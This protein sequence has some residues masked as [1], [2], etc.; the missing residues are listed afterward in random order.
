MIPVY[1]VKIHEDYNPLNLANDIAIL[2]LRNPA[3]L[4]TT[5]MPICLPHADQNYTGV[6]ATVSGWGRLTEN[7][8]LSKT[9]QEAEVEVVSNDYCAAVYTEDSVTDNH[10]CAGGN[11]TDSCQADSGGPLIPEETDG[12]NYL[13]GITS[14]GRGCGRVG[15]P[16]VYMRVA[17]YLEWIAKQVQ[18]DNCEYLSHLP[19]VNTEVPETAT[20]NF[21]CSCGIRNTGTRIIGGKV[22]QVHE[23]P[24]QVAIVGYYGIQPFCGAVVLSDEWIMTAAHCAVEMHLDD[25]LMLGEHDWKHASE[26]AITL[27]RS[28]AQIIIHPDYD[29]KPMDS[30][31]ALLKLGEPLDFSQYHNAIAPVCLPAPGA[32]FEGANALVTGWGV[33]SFGGLQS[34]TLR[35]VEVPIVRRTACVASYGK[36]ITKNMIC[37]GYRN[38]GKDACQGD[39]GGPLVVEGENG[40]Y[41]LAGVVSWGLKCAKPNYYGVYAKVSNFLPW[42]RGHIDGS[43]TCQSS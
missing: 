15:Y 9:L 41:I 21:T 17:R 26:S 23:F 32:T 30:D 5:V 7:G 42:I 34:I 14:W 27:R 20:S 36:Y 35:V 40:E 28:I 24:W 12:S 3:E 1:M 38:G 19:P 37:A 8:K 10:V 29:K 43:E 6:L 33:I 22:S 16:G 25:Q 4:G 39:S 31:L 2:Y 13:I 11:G 18:T